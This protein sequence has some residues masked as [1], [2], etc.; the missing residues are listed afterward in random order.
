MTLLIINS[1]QAIIGKCA[2]HNC[3]EG[4]K[5]VLIEDKTTCELACK[6]KNSLKKI[7]EIYHVVHKCMVSKVYI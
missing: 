4:Y 6:F 3:A 2:R 7:T 5:C 1:F